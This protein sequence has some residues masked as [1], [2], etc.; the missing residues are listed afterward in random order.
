MKYCILFLFSLIQFITNAQKATGSSSTGISSSSVT[1][2]I[3]NL[4][5]ITG[6]KFFTVDTKNTSYAYLYSYEDFKK[7]LKIKISQGEDKSQL[8]NI[9][10][11]LDGYFI[12]KD[13]LKPENY[14]DARTNYNFKSYFKEFESDC[15]I[16]KNFLIIEKITKKRETTLV[17]K[18]GKVFSSIDGRP[19]SQNEYFLSDEKTSIYGNSIYVYKVKVGK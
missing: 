14:K 10:I 11:F 13:T 4:N 7:R 19:G 17:H 16:N 8:Q 1:T 18:Q 6:N 2:T 5:P 3:I 15:W 9:I 12:N